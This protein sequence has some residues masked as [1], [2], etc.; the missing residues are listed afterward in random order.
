MRR[1]NNWWSHSVASRL[2]VRPGRRRLPSWS[3]SSPLI[4]RHRSP[5]ANTSSTAARFRRFDLSPNDESNRQGEKSAHGDIERSQPA[6][7]MEDVLEGGSECQPEEAARKRRQDEQAPEGGSLQDGAS[8]PGA[9][10]RARG[11]RAHEPGLRVDPLKDRR[12]HVADGLP[13]R[14]RFDAA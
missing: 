1:A 13:F 4:A 6:T 2:A 9:E 7:A 3:P 14:H 5:E 10:K 8:R 12:A 11:A